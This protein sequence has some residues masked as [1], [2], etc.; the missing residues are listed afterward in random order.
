MKKNTRFIKQRFVVVGLRALVIAGLEELSPILL[1]VE[2]LVV[3]VEEEP[4]PMR[5]LPARARSLIVS[6][7]NLPAIP[8]VDTEDTI[9][10]ERLMGRIV[11]MNAC[12]RIEEVAEAMNLLLSL[13]DNEE[14]LQEVFEQV[15]LR[16]MDGWLGR[17]VY[18]FDMMRWEVDLCIPLSMEE[19]DAIF[20]TLTDAHDTPDRSSSPA[21]YQGEV[22]D[23]DNNSLDS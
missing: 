15:P 11:L 6:S 17:L 3:A 7:E 14:R 18:R 4:R 8:E 20:S 13:P 19:G 9:L 5:S 21:S 12:P 1:K 10:P 16:S 22:L 2:C 23:F